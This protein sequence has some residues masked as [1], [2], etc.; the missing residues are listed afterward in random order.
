M[1]S[2]ACFFGNKKVTKVTL[3]GMKK[4]EEKMEKGDEEKSTDLCFVPL[5]T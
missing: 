1:R 2:S 3:D 4:N 5:F